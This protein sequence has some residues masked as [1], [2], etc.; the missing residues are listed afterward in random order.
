MQRNLFILNKADIYR[1]IS[2]VFYA[3]RIAMLF[4]KSSLKNRQWTEK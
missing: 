4:K 2:I 1:L 3:F